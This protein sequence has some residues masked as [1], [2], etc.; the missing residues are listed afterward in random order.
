LGAVF[1]P[2]GKDPLYIPGPFI[3]LAG[4]QRERRMVAYLNIPFTVIFYELRRTDAEHLQDHLMKMTAV[5]KP[6][7]DRCFAYRSPVHDLADGK[8]NFIPDDISMQRNAGIVFE[9]GTQSA[10]R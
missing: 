3:I 9:Q 1:L 4:Y 10:G 7:T 2:G 8:G 6:A 5:R